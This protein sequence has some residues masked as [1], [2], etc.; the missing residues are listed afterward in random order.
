MIA[1]DTNVLVYAHR[2]EMPRHKEA[3]EI[4]NAALMSNEGVGLCW[5][6]IHEFLAT[7]TNP[8]IFPSPT[9]LDQAFA[10]I[11]YWRTAP[12]TS[13][14]R[15]GPH[16]LEI[17]YGLCAGGDVAGGAVHDARIAAVCIENGV[18]EIWT[19]DRDFAKFEGLV[20]RNPLA[21]D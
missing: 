5:S 10:Q 4:V 21:I 19:A 2:F 9:P 14:L 16:H 6:V 8:R 20:S 7:V 12:N 18:R 15:E 13:V 1:I 17:L 11:E 3:L